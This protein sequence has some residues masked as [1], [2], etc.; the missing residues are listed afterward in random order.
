MSDSHGL[1]RARLKPN[2][3]VIWHGHPGKSHHIPSYRVIFVLLFLAIGTLL[4]I[5]AAAMLSGGDALSGVMIGLASALALLI[6]WIAFTVDGRRAKRTT[7]ALT[8]QGRAIILEGRIG[9]PIFKAVNIG[10]N[11][12]LMYAPGAQ[13]AILFTEKTVWVM[14]G[15]NNTLKQKSVPDGFFR[16]AEPDLVYQLMENIKSKGA[17]APQ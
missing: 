2:E 1:V 13:P 15:R 4:G 10:P 6:S 14:G 11:T 17:G 7:Y 8:D 9:G 12:P 16:V 5:L 3:K